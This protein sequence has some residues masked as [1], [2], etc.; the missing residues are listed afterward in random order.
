MCLF[1]E[2]KRVT[3]LADRLGCDF[4][5]IHRERHHKPQ[6]QKGP[7]GAK[8]SSDEIEVRLTLV[9]DVKGKVCFL[10]V[11]LKKKKT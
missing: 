5:M 4:A 7:G 11:K 8:T 6:A 10:M 2:A 3:S 1:L 9:G